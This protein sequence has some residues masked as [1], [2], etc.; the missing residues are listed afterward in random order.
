MIV[1]RYLSTLAV[2]ILALFDMLLTVVAGTMGVVCLRVLRKYESTVWH[3]T[4]GA[5]AKGVTR[6]FNVDKST[7]V[8]TP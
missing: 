2:V 4:G 7:T 5:L 3:Q 8:S 6:T 1:V